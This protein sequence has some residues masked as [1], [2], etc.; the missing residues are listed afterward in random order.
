MLLMQGVE[1]VKWAPGQENF[2][3]AVIQDCYIIRVNCTLINKR[4]FLYIFKS[5]FLYIFKSNFLL[6]IFKSNEDFAIT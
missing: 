6:Y 5:N 1:D 2:L 4:F 3:E